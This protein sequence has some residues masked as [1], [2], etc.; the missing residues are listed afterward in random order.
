MEVRCAG[1]QSTENRAL[2][3][4][5][6]HP[7]AAHHGAT[8]IRGLHDVTGSLVGKGNRGWSV[9]RLETSVKPIFSGED[10]E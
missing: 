9:V 3:F 10:T 2:E 6:I 1:S 7:L 8:G 4:A 5:D